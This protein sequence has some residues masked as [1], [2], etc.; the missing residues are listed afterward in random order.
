MSHQDW[1]PIVFNNPRQS[2]VKFSG[3]SIPEE[4]IRMKKLEEETYVIPKVS[5]ALQQQI[6]EARAAKGW[7][8][9]E[10]AAKINVKQNIINGYESGNVIPDNQTVQKLS[11][12]L[13]VPL[14]LRQ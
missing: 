12:A 13:G 2:K 14:K 10:L 3:P 7:T 8:Q 1:N 6:R 5:V 11:R 4:V 9:K